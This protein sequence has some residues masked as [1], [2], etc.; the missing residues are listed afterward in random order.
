M[1]YTL[2]DNQ[3]IKDNYQTMSSY[4][5]AKHLG[6]KQGSVSRKIRQLGLVDHETSQSLFK[7]GMR[8]CS[9]GKHVLPLDQFYLLSSGKYAGNC[10]EC[11]RDLSRTYHYDKY[12]SLKTYSESVVKTLAKRKVCTVTAK[13]IVDQFKAQD[14]KCFFS[15]VPMAIEANKLE[16][17]SV[18]RL[19]PDLPYE[20]TNVVLC[21]HI[22]NLMKQQLQVK[23]F[24]DWCEKI[25]QASRPT[26]SLPHSV[27]S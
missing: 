22:V 10:K 14:G 18:D 16:T 27:V 5:I 25:L 23:D 12:D 21:C 2:T 6:R 1:E 11:C 15:G 20:P 24:I 8:R 4:A 13:Q 17:V 19:N 7:R 9:K 3:F 26:K